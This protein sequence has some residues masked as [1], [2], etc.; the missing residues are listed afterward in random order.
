MLTIS[1]IV[2]KSAQKYR[3]ISET[4]MRGFMIIYFDIRPLISANTSLSEILYEAILTAKFIGEDLPE[5]Y[6]KLILNYLRKNNNFYL[7][8][9]D[10]I[11]F[12]TEEGSRFLNF[13]EKVLKEALNREYLS[14]L[15]QCGYM[16]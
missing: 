12:V 2:D 10:K 5:N 3:G 8:I 7:E 9:E 16:E 13:F 6:A 1:I 14:L 11:I 15:K 4:S